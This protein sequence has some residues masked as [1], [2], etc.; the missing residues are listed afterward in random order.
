M[1]AREQRKNKLSCILEQHQ[2]SNFN[3]KNMNLKQFELG[4]K[5]EQFRF[6]RFDY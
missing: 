6:S 5:Y 3:E 1:S 4:L 2:R